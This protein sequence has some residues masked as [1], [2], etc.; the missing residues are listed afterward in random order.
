MSK[1]TKVV[2]CIIAFVMLIGLVLSTAFVVEEADHN[3]S[4]IEC[5]ICEAIH[6]DLKN[7]INQI[8]KSNVIILFVC[9][10]WSLILT[11]GIEKSA[12]RIDTLV[13]SKMKLSN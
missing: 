10:V 1:Y 2:S 9:G 6:F 12:F 7:F 11:L 13:N 3:C 5:Q 8:P 4:G